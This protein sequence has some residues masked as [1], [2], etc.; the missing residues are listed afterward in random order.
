MTVEHV[1]TISAIFTD[2]AQGIY[3]VSSTDEINA[4]EQIEEAYGDLDDYEVI[5]TSRAHVEYQEAA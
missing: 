1:F 2:G 4:V 5:A 3:D